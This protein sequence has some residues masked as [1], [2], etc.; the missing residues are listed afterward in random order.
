MQN[1]KKI[2]KNR[3]ET[4]FNTTDDGLL[5]WYEFDQGTGD[6]TDL[7]G[8]AGDAT[9]V[10]AASVVDESIGIA[11]QFPGSNYAEVQSPSSDLQTIVT[12]ASTQGM[13]LSLW[14]KPITNGK[15]VI[16]S[17]K[18]AVGT[19]R[20]WL[21]FFEPGG[22]TGNEIAC[23]L[24]GVLTYSGIVPQVNQWYHVVVNYVPV[25]P[26][27]TFGR[28]YLWVNGVNPANASPEVDIDEGACGNLVIAADKVLGSN[29][30]GYLHQGF[31]YNR[32]LL[33][34]EIEALYNKGVVQFQGG[35]GVPETG[36]VVLD[37]IGETP[38]MRQ[39]GS[40][41]IATE[42]IDGEKVK[43]IECT[44][45][46]T[47]YAKV[48]ELNMTSSEA[49]YGTW[50]WWMY[51]DIKANDISINFIDNNTTLADAGG[52]ALRWR[53]NDDL[54][55]TEMGVTEQ[56]QTANDYCASGNWYGFKITRSPQG[57]FFAQIKGGA[58]GP[59]YGPILLVGGSGANPVTDN[60]RVVSNYLL[61]QLYA[62][63]KLAWGSVNDKY[64][65][66]KN[67]TVK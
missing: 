19:G 63:D 21:S 8:G 49:A 45:A 30:T 10:T 28:V 66:T 41:N 15:Q 35:Y 31:V 36:T 1:T 12:D 55:L 65:F 67:L 38:F 46:G 60:T 40:Y 27:D 7:I 5:G 6:I 11:S 13:A 2:S 14:V 9:I 61:V 51:K 20:D 24:G 23:E 26:G 25:Q 58:F 59:D 62:G 4:Y 29:F 48:D 54:R 57:E 47:F 17:Q 18:N 33:D 42:V 64:S 39:S 43:V 22:V 53:T 32:F 16:V 52:Y 37:Q 50:E 3:L 34:G 56:F 44:V